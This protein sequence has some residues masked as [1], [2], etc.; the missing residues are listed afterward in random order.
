MSWR[1]PLIA[2]VVMICSFA[3]AGLGSEER[4][5]LPKAG[6]P[7]A[8]PGIFRAT[9]A[10]D[11][12]VRELPAGKTAVIRVRV[13]NTSGLPWPSSTKDSVRL[14]YH[15]LKKDGKPAVWDGERS[16]IPKALGPGEETVLAANVKVPNERGPYVLEFDLVVDGQGGGWFSRK[17]GSTARVDVEV[18]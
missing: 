1:L 17:G 12:P 2:A 5:Q 10:V 11:N 4:K 3:T 14:S 13:K 16:F 18:K 8:A 6:A 9:I 7:A 15:W